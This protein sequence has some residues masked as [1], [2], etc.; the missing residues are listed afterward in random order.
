MRFEFATAT[1]IIFGDGTIYEVAP[2]AAEMGRRALTQ[3]ARFSWDR[4][5]RA[6]LAAYSDAVN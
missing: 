2:L 3:S 5:A 4:T 1:R 6:T